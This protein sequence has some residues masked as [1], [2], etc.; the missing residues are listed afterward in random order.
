VAHTSPYSDPRHYSQTASETMDLGER[1]WER[2]ATAGE[3]ARESA[4]E[5]PIATVAVIAGLAF[6]IGALW[7]IGHPRQQS[8]FEALR[9][10]LADLPSE[11]PRRW[12]Y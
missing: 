8:R 2:A 12:R 6:A 3:A 5:H 10:R 9:S 11:L 4:R 7:K 1:V